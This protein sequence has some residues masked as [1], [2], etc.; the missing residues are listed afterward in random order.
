MF[1]FGK[2]ILQD[3]NGVSPRLTCV[4]SLSFHSEFFY[5]FKSLFVII[6]LN[7]LIKS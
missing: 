3:F 1:W 4:H 2:K 5:N 7:S 6:F